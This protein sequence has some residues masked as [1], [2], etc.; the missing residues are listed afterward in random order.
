MVRNQRKR[1]LIN[2]R[3]KSA[4]SEEFRVLRTNIELL[5]GKRKVKTLL[6]T[7]SS[8]KEGKSTIVSNLASILGEQSKRVLI[9]DA[10]LRLPTQHQ[11][12]KQSNLAGLSDFL[13][14]K[15]NLEA[16]IQDSYLKNVDF[17]PSGPSPFNPSELLSKEAFTNLLQDLE[18]LYDYIIID[19]SPITVIDSQIIAS[20]I[21]SVI[22]VVEENKTATAKFNESLSILRRTRAHVLGIILNKTKEKKSNYYYYY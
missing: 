4:I 5:E 7:S 20:K 19:S 10:D 1:L 14:G 18:P 17:I 16:I 15:S 6:L 22:L 11:I 2:H 9:I 13:T 8:P 21:D 12:L 3:E